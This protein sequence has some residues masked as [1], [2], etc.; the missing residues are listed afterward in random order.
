MATHELDQ[1]VCHR[2]GWSAEYEYVPNVG[3][4]CTVTVGLNDRREF[5]SNNMVSTDPKAGKTAAATAA[6]Q[7]LREEIDRLESMPHRELSEVFTQPIPI[8]E[9]NRANWTYFW[10]HKP[11]IVGIDTEGN[12]SYPP[13]LVQVA[14]EDYCILEVPSHDISKDLMRLLADQEIIKV[15]CDNLSHKDKKVFKDRQYS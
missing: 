15:F 4:V 3:W 2:Y 6:L 12:R 10:N 1:S 14:T 13:I 7:G 5:V 9:S 11:K 8:Y